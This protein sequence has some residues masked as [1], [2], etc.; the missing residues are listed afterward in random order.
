MRSLYFAEFSMLRRAID[1]V[2]SMGIIRNECERILF[3]LPGLCAAN[4]AVVSMGDLAV[5]K[6]PA[7]T[8]PLWQ[9]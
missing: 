3:A 9:G 1:K 4:V 8:G 6:V 2:A 5:I 7:A